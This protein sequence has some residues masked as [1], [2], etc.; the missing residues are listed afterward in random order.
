M[1]GV[2]GLLVKK[3]IVNGDEYKSKKTEQLEYDTLPPKTINL[4]GLGRLLILEDP[5]YKAGDLTAGYFPMGLFGMALEMKYAESI[6]RKNNRTKDETLYEKSLNEIRDGW[7]LLI[8]IDCKWIDYSKLAARS[9]IKVLNKNGIKNV[10]LKFSG[11][12]GFHILVP[13]KAFPKEINGIPSKN[14]FPELPRKIVGYLRF[15]AEK[16]MKESLPE[17]FYSHFKDTKIN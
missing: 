4:S 9:I 10:G 8:D 5:S 13:W 12:K 1:L 2:A 14:L 7:D 11:S 3:G 16:E 17:D 15:M 6:E